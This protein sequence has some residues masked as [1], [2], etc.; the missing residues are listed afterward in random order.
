MYEFDLCPQMALDDIKARL[1][2]REDVWESSPHVDNN[3]LT[4]PTTTIAQALETL[5]IEKQFPSKLSDFSVGLLIHAIY[6]HTRLMLLP[7]TRL[8]T[9]TP[10][11]SAKRRVTTQ[12]AILQ[13]S[14][15]PST[16]LAS[17]WRN[18][19]CDSLDIL[20]WHA[21]SKIAKSAGFEHHTILHLH[22]ARI[23]ILTPTKCI[24]ELVSALALRSKDG[25]LTDIDARVSSARIE[26]TQWVLRDCFKAR[27]AVIHCAA[28]YW[29]VRRYSCDDIQEP[30][31]IYV[32]TLMLWGFSVAMR[33]PE[34]LE[35]IASDDNE[36]PDPSFC[37]LDRPLDDELVQLFV[38]VG[39]RM[40][41]NISKVGNILDSGAASK[42]LAEGHYL[43]TASIRTPPRSDTPVHRSRRCTWGIEASYASSLSD[44]LAF[45]T[46]SSAD[47]TGLNG[48]VFPWNSTR[49]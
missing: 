40:R 45:S 6:R 44:V 1:P 13:P 28:L 41:P 11:A 10:T 8:N 33:L 15:L 24:K 21:N 46:Q 49:C 9:W 47:S 34:V 27:L 23:I 32:A 17:K 4:F 12:P 42:V 20:H 35:A 30:F 29:H 31:A 5:Y 25:D 48:L 18:S 3:N 39:H 22:L 2:S 43:L 7:S 14:W 37:H 16:Q 19:A 36:E 38:R 26:L